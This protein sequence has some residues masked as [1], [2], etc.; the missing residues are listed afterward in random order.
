MKRVRMEG[1]RAERE[2]RGRGKHHAQHTEHEKGG[3]RG[4]REGKHHAHTTHNTHHTPHT[5]TDPFPISL[6][7]AECQVAVREYRELPSRGLGGVLGPAV[8]AGVR[9]AVALDGELV[10][11]AEVADDVLGVVPARGHAVP[12]V[13]CDSGLVLRFSV[14]GYDG[15]FSHCAE[16]GEEWGGWM[17][18]RGWG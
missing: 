2:R 16:G 13:E 10:R 11:V 9:D 1:E 12:V 3:E 14:G 18:G 5:A 8:G 15:Y 7:L 6:P 17:A 4:G